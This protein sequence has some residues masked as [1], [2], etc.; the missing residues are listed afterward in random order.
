MAGINIKERRIVD[1]ADS[2]GNRIDTGTLLL[3]RIT[4]HER[5]RRCTLQVCRAERWVF[6]Y[7]NYGRGSSE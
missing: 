6:L 7:H 3:L 2:N 5:A 1:I 4:S